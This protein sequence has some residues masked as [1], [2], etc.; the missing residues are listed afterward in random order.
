MIEIPE[1]LTLAEQL[2]GTV[3]GKRVLHVLPPTKLHK[4]CWFS[5]DAKEY[6]KK[7]AGSVIESASAFGIYVELA[8]ANGHKLCFNDGVNVRYLNAADLPNE[9]QLLIM[10]EGGTALCFTVAMYG[11]LILHSGEYDNE[12]YLKSKKAVSPFAPEFEAY[13]RTL[14]TESKASLSM[15][16]FLAANQ[17]IPGVGNGT[18]QDI[19]FA[20]GLH[21]KRK[22]STLT[23]EDEEFLLRS[24]VSVLREMTDAGGR[25]TENDLFGRAGRY[26]TKMSKNTIEVPSPSIAY[27]QPYSGRVEQLFPCISQPGAQ[28]SG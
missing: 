17:R 5:G 22:L 11:G 7:I 12:Y 18:V 16:A 23:H 21:P 15:K 2:T 19:L 27:T 9:Y 28:H 25:D 4:F 14:L 1:G 3:S 20:A 13:Y 10:L 8:F 26:Q 24:L 6:D